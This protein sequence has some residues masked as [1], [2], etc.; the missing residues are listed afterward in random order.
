MHVV[1]VGVD[2]R[3]A[4]LALRERIAVLDDRLPDVLRTLAAEP[5]LSEVLV[6]ST[7]NRTEVYAV[8]PEREAT[9]LLLG[10]LRRVVVGAPPEEDEAWARRSGE[11]AARHLFRVVSGLESAIL[12]ET[13]IQGQV[14]ESHRRALE[15]K[16]VG[17]VLDRLVS[18]ALRAGK[19]ARTDTPLCR[20][21]VSHGQAA[22][23]VTR[24]VF[25]GLRNRTVL[26]VGAGEM[27]RLAATSI[28]ALPEGRF[29]VANRT[30]E[31]AEALARTLP[32]ATVVGLD[33]VPARLAEAHVA[34]FAGGHAALG[35]AE[36]E[37]AAARR[38]DPLL[39]LD[40]GVPR[41]VDPA[42]VEIPGVFLYDL[43]AIERLLASSLAGRREAV[44]AVEAI[45]ETELESFRAWSRTRLAVPAIRSLQA[46]AEEIRRQELGRLPEDTPAPLREAFESLSRRIVD[47]ILRRP[48]EL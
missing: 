20:G 40:F 23:E 30:R 24:Q 5:W 31:A 39:I 1:Q 28:A 26:V 42:V 16:A 32:Q 33:E 13:E 3:T 25:G 34:L 22:C 36:A 14:K 15:A 47:R 27:A 38:R 45:L 17:P 7:C 43:E 37:A 10:A 19:R 41:C 4:P 44:P 6:V 48:A 11:E 46:W 8:S 35:R 18:T 9:T 29:I 2:H 12:G 21:A